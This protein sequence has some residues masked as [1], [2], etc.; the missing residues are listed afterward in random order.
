MSIMS[1][2]YMFPQAVGSTQQQSQPAIFRP[3]KPEDWEPYYEV[4]AHYYNT[5]NM[6]LKDVMAE[7]ETTYYFKATYA[8]ISSLNVGIYDGC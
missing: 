1:D 4:I 3:S 8:P 6:R 2:Y 5:M 7:M